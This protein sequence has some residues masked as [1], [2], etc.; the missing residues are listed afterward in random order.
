[1]PLI[2]PD[3]SRYAYEHTTPESSLLTQLIEKTQSE[4]EYSEML[5]GRVEGRFLSMLVKISG[6][7]NIL[8]IGMFTGFSALMMAEAL[9]PGGKIITCDVNEYYA[10]IARSFFE[11]SPHADRIE[12]RIG[13]AVETIPSLSGPFD[14]AFIDADKDLYPDYY[15]LILPKISEGGMIILDNALRSGEVLKPETRQAKA[16]DRVNKMIQQDDD[17]ENVLLTVRDGIQ[18]VRKK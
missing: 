13:K 2:D 15:K 6:A 10:G 4:L 16:I 5:S 3:L 17:V 8:E 11:R 9:P 7:R 18:L 14:L 1:M 12:V